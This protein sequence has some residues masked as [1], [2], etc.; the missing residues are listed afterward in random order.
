MASEERMQT[1]AGALRLF[2]ARGFDREMSVRRARLH[3]S[4]PERD[5]GP[6]DV[7]VRDHRRFEGVSDPGDTSVVYAIETVDGVRGTLVDGYN[8][9]ADPAIGDFLK[10]VRV[11]EPATSET[12]VTLL[13]AAVTTAPPEP[14]EPESPAATKAKDDLDT[15]AVFAK[16]KQLGGKAEDK[17]E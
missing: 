10:D 7:R 17:D 11:Q 8:V 15:A 1:V 4:G 12:G 3:V 14:A 13:P 5:Y 6:A 16:L 2:A 9:Y